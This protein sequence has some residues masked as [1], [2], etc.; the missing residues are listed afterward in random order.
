MP[1]CRRIEEITVLEAAI[2][3]FDSSRGEST[4]LTSMSTIAEGAPGLLYGRES[5]VSGPFKEQNREAR[6][7]SC[8]VWQ[9][10]CKHAFDDSDLKSFSSS[11]LC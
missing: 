5:T 4:Q 8:S 7:R 3:R 6:W 1:I 11:T 2:M 9:S 10:N